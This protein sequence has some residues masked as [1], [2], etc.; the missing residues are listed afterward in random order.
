MARRGK[1]LCWQPEFEQ[2][3]EP[4]YRWIQRAC[5]TEL[6]YE[7]HLHIE[8]CI[9]FVHIYTQIII[10]IINSQKQQKWVCKKVIPKAFSWLFTDSSFLS[11]SPLRLPRFCLPD[12]CCQILKSSSLLWPWWIA[13]VFD[14]K[15]WLTTNLYIPEAI[16]VTSSIG[17]LG[18]MELTRSFCPNYGLANTYH[19]FICPTCFVPSR[20]QSFLIQQNFINFACILHIIILTSL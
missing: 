14:Q 10:I 11:S 12:P 5:S 1:S 20:A 15:I 7:F 6:S 3:L 13:R 17:V 16:D 2:D 9:Y 8:E 4:R 19:L 18:T